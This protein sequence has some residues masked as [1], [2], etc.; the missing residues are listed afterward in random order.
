MLVKILEQNVDVATLRNEVTKILNHP[1]VRLDLI[2]QGKEAILLQSNIPNTD[3]WLEGITKD[4]KT[5]YADK[6]FYN[7]LPFLKNTLLAHYIS[8]YKTFR[9]RLMLMKS[10]KCI[11]VH[12]DSYPRI[13]IPIHTNDQCFMVWPQENYVYHLEAGKIYWADTTKKHTAFNG[14]LSDPQDRDSPYYSPGARI[15]LV[16]SIDDNL[17]V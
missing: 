17:S 4:K 13:H 15:H 8:K 14:A 16:M 3:V 2:N 12:T 7:I 5:S 11:P 10:R 6:D 9:S 1:P